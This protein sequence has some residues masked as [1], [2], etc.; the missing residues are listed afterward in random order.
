MKRFTRILLPVMILAA[1]FA[2]MKILGSF[3]TQEEKPPLRSGAREGP[4][5]SNCEDCLGLTDHPLRN[6][7]RAERPGADKGGG[8]E[9]CEQLS[10]SGEIR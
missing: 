8:E 4:Q 9:E 1:G 10:E 5:T 3:E 7:N 6:P 2:A